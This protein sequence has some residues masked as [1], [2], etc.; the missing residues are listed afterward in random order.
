MLLKPL[1]R[2]RKTIGFSLAL[3]NSIIFFLRFVIIFTFAY[4]YLS[5]TIRKYDRESVR[6]ELNECATQFQKGGIDALKSEVDIETQAAGGRNLFFVRLA[7]AENNTL[8]LNIPDQWEGFDIHQLQDRHFNPYR[9]WLNVK[10]KGNVVEIASL[11]LPDGQFLQIGKSSEGRWNLLKRFHI[12]F[13]GIFLP[14]ILISFSGGV[15]LAHRSLQPIRGFISTLQSIIATGKMDVRVPRRQTGGELDELAVM[16]NGMLEKIEVLLNGMK[17]SLDNVAHDLRTPLARLRG[18]AE[19][20]LR[21]EQTVDTLR[22]SLVDCVEESERVLTML[23]TLMDISEAEAGVMK[24]DL[25]EVKILNLMEDVIELYT[26]VAE[27]KD[28]AIHRTCPE[29]LCLTVDP[30]RMQQVL[31]NLL[32]N[33]IKYTPSGGRVDIEVKQEQRQFVI[34]VKDT[35]IGIP[36]EELFR[37][38]DRLHRVDKSRSGRGLGLGLSLVK[39]IVEAHKGKADVSSE[40]GVGSVFS[41]YLPKN[42]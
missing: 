16:F 35:G 25:K 3:W 32:D 6:M 38:W 12:A 33:G 39:A 14:V 23:N 10:V 41:I 19:M 8:F 15:F 27:E 26:Y 20:A 30:N 2:M 29:E 13:A 11:R 37:V 18:K 42:L 24:L 36:P 4:L 28:I 1:N 34:T 31:A 17:S 40:P 5:P 22:E 7:G 21:S 9:E